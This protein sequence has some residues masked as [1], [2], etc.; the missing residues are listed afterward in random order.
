MSQKETETMLTLSIII[1]VIKK[2]YETLSNEVFTLPL[3]MANYCCLLK[4]FVAS[5]F[6]D[7][8]RV[9]GLSKLKFIR[10]F[11]CSEMASCAGYGRYIC[12]HSAFQLEQNA[13][14]FDLKIT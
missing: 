7:F 4:P 1:I 12:F 10:H 11:Q 2:V 6:Y 13:L 8:V 3:K 14:N 9:N 5:R